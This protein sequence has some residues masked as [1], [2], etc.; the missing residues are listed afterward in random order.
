MAGQRREM[1]V[2]F[3]GNKTEYET[4]PLDLLCSPAG[5]PYSDQ[6]MTKVRP[7]QC[8]ASQWQ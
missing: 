2:L 6:I 3:L 8:G 7:G 5:S 1:S 4:S